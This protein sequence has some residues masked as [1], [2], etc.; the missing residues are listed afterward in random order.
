[1]ATLKDLKAE[2]ARDSEFARAYEETQPGLA[3]MRAIADA[4][5]ERN[6]T[7]KQIAELTGIAQTEISKLENGRDR[8]FKS[9]NAHHTLSVRTICVS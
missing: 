6:L 3:V 7:Q 4:R 9:C 8:L 2:L 1:M 5:S